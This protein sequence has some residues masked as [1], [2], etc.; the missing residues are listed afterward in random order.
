MKNLN[1]ELIIDII[2]NE[3]ESPSRQVHQSSL[4]CVKAWFY[5]TVNTFHTIDF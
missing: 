3:L 5:C 1:S 4:Y 2:D